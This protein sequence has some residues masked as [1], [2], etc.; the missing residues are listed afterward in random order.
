M[1][2]ETFKHLFNFTV[3]NEKLYKIERIILQTLEFKIDFCTPILILHCF[4]YQLFG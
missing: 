2:V 4:A 3:S 1:D